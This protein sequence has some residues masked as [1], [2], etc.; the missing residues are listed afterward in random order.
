[1]GH[2]TRNTDTPPAHFL[3]TFKKK[4]KHTFCS[5]CPLVF[6]A[7]W[8]TPLFLY[9]LFMTELQTPRQPIQKSEKVDEIFSPFFSFFQGVFV[10]FSPKYVFF[11]S[12]IFF[13][14][15]NYFSQNWIQNFHTFS[16]LAQR[17]SHRMRNFKKS[18]R[19]KYS[20]LHVDHDFST[21]FPLEQV[22]SLFSFCQG[23]ENSTSK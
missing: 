13:P 14:G 6:D 12:C 15:C 8:P 23:G 21:H 11:V 18:T 3:S 20:F 17:S 10:F 1:M 19:T 22:F 5:S 4:L 2:S 7:W 16:S 9:L